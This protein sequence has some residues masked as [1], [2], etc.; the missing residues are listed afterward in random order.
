MLSFSAHN[1]QVFANYSLQSIDQIKFNIGLETTVNRAR[2]EPFEIKL[3]YCS[4]T[5]LIIQLT[6]LSQLAGFSRS[7]YFHRP[8]SLATQIFGVW[9]SQNGMSIDYYLKA[10][11]SIRQTIHDPL[12][13]IIYTIFSLS[14]GFIS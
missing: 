14:S 1:Y 3:F 4:N 7:I 13:T 8:E 2:P 9:R 10:P 11:Q 6:I 12:H 5:S